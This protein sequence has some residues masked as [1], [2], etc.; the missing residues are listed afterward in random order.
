MPAQIKRKDFVKVLEYLGLKL[1]RVKG[2]HSI[3]KKEGLLRPVVIAK[4][5]DIPLMHIQTNLKTL[6]ISLTEFYEILNHKI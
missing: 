6:G 2:D 1:D 4:H 3:Y 5:K